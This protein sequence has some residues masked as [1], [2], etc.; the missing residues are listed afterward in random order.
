MP[1]G[2][3]AAIKDGIDFKTYALG[4][5][6]NFGALVMMR[7]EPS[8]IPIPERFEPSDFS[9][10]ELQ[11]A[12]D[13]LEL[14]NLYSNNEWLELRDMEYKKDVEYYAK[15]KSEEIELKTKYTAMLAQA[16]SW[17]APTKEHTGLRDFMIKQIE[18][19]IQWDCTYYSDGGRLPK[20]KELDS[21]IENKIAGA[22]RDIGYYTNSHKEEIE[23][24]NDRNKW[25]SDLRNSL[26]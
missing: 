23:R 1:T 17:V 14:F 26:K 25:I 15:A 18:D 11:K 8:N 20:K 12:I 22:K 7:D 2:Y 13:K 9:K 10:K 6:R 4:C 19:S 3:T 24:T 21:F 5:A 16:K